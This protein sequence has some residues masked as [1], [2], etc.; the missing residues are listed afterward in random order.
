[1]FRKFISRA[2]AALLFGGVEPFVQIGKRA[3]W[4]I[5]VRNIFNL[6]RWFRR[7]CHLKQTLM[8]GLTLARRRQITIA[9]LEPL[10]YVS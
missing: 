6:D 1:M 4:G 3:L 2:L 10:A 9:Y 7:S 8:D 5:F